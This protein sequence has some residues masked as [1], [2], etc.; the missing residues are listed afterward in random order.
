ME[1]TKLLNLLEDNLS[2]DY[3][4]VVPS[5]SSKFIHEN[6]PIE[7]ETKYKKK[8]VFFGGEGFI[9][10]AKD[11]TLDFRKVVIKVASRQVRSDK[12]LTTKF[13]RGAAIQAKISSLLKHGIPEIYEAGNCWYV[14]EFIRGLDSMEFAERATEEEININF[15]K[16][17]AI[18]HL[19]HEFCIIHRDVKPENILITTDLISGEQYP[20]L[21]D[22]GLSKIIDKDAETLTRIG[23]SMGSPAFMSDVMATDAAKASP[24]DDIYALGNL[25]WSW[26]TK[27]RPKSDDEYEK[28][29]MEHQ[30]EPPQQWWSIYEKATHKEY[31]TC[32]AMKKDIENN[33]LMKEVDFND[34]LID[35]IVKFIWNAMDAKPVG[36]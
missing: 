10:L 35:K 34:E 32:L 8:E 36:K 26:M 9:F 29:F 30:G 22:W 17:L 27:I 19:M 13:F 3:A 11:S 5:I 20:V 28:Y 31:K 21:I 15:C 16:L 24:L 18:C 25:Y 33:I 4:A 23:Q 6:W 7:A 1:T 2:K 12:K 14:M